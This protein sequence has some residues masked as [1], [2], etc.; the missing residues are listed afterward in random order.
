MLMN[1]GDQ[2]VTSRNHLLSTV[3][4]GLPAQAG[5]APVTAAAV[6]ATAA[7]AAAATAAAATATAATATAASAAAASAAAATSIAAWKPTFMLEGGVFMAGAAVQWLRD[8]LGIIQHSED[9]EALA[10]SVAD[11]D[12]VFMVPAFAGLGAPH[13]DPYARGTLV[14]L[15]RGTT[16][17][18]IARATLEAIALQSAELLTAMNADSGIDLSELR[19]DGGAARN[20]LLMQM[21]ADLL[22]VPVVRPQVPESTARGAAGLAGLAVGFWSGLDEFASHWHA[23]RRFEPNWSAEQREARIRR[24]R[25][26]VELSKGWAAGS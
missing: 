11:T 12:D 16:R 23:E 1:V 25:Q 19:V 21:Q 4:W 17:A 20:D 6:A 24:W 5:N 14:G 9:V 18:H 7:T 8:G 3:G 15:T 13:W 10:G 2:P 22:G 26:A